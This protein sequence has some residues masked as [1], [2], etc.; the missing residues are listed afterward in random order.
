[1]QIVLVAV[2]MLVTLILGQL[3]SN[4]A[5]V[6]I[7]IPIAVALADGMQASP[8]PFLMGLAVSGAC[9]LYTSRCV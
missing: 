8:L 2:L 3:I 1:M 9:L 5:T 7:M 6:L 4:T